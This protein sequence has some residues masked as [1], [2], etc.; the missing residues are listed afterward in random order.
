MLSER[1]KQ[2]RLCPSSFSKPLRLGHPQGS[3]SDGSNPMA[4]SLVV[5]M[6]HAEKPSDPKDPDL[7]AAGFERAQKLAQYILQQFGVADFLFATAISKHS[8]RPYETLKPLSKK[9]GIPNQLIGSKIVGRLFDA[10]VFEL[11]SGV[12]SRRTRYCRPHIAGFIHHA[13]GTNAESDEQQEE[14]QADRSYVN[15]LTG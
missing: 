1:F 8:A 11:Q 9:I 10:M 2:G 6:R 5:L 4:P 7:S 13:S 3:F 12:T 14:Q 15:F